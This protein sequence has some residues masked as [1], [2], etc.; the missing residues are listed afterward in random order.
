MDTP[1]QYTLEFWLDSVA[2]KIIGGMIQR[3]LPDSCRPTGCA[4][5]R[6]GSGGATREAFA[7]RGGGR[8]K[9]GDE[10]QHP[11]LDESW[12][13]EEGVLVIFHRRRDGGWFSSQGDQMRGRIPGWTRGL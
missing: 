1:G 12:R 5:M 4:H 7:S 11:Y 9:T 10:G 8:A 13:A 6:A 3:E 2:I